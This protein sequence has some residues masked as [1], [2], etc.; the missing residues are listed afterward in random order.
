MI[1]Q[2]VTYQNS[3]AGLPENVVT[4]QIIMVEPLDQKK[5]FLL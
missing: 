5:L 4:N 3:L 2:D 1:V